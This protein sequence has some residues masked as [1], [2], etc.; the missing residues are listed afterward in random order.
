[1]LC[2]EIFG[3]LQIS[4]VNPVRQR[5]SKTSWNRIGQTVILTPLLE[6]WSLIKRRQK[7]NFLH[8]GLL[9]QESTRNIQI[10]PA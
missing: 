10:H 6:T 8:V 1:M 5:I 4:C 9:L 7:V 3:V 2:F